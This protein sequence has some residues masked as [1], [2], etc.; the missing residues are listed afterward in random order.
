MMSDA[1]LYGLRDP[2]GLVLSK[3]RLNAVLP[4]V[5][6]HVVDL[7][8]GDNRLVRQVGSGIGID[9]DSRGQSD[10]LEV[11][12]FTVL[13]LA[14]DSV[15]VVTIIASL[16]YFDDPH[17]VLAECRRILKPSGQILLTMAKLSVM[18][19]WHKFR[20]PW[21]KAP[22][23]SED[24]LNLMLQEAGFSILL[25][26]SFMLGMNMIVI[27][28]PSVSSNGNSDLGANGV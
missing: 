6:G 9:I 25:R 18:A 12:D 13:P 26:K 16:N 2:I 15:D 8:C 21:V 27:A 1:P 17:R 4:H 5:R 10:V 24:E 14:D 7:A 22:A 23:I 28:T 19:V 3:W 11:K 20:D